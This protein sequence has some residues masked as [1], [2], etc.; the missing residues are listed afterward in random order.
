MRGGR[1]GRGGTWCDRGGV[2]NA[3]AERLFDDVLNGLFDDALYGCRCCSHLS[4][5]WENGDECEE[6]GFEESGEH[7][8]VGVGVGACDL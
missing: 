2:F 1:E 8:R 7:C 6:D 5:R 4:Y 3:S